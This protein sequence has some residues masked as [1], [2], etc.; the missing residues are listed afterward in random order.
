IKI[1]RTTKCDK[2]SNHL[3]VV[4][5]ESQDKA[6]LKFKYGS[7]EKNGYYYPDKHK[8]IIVGHKYY[9]P[10]FDED[11]KSKK[12]VELNKGK[13]TYITDNY[14]N[15]YTPY[16][17]ALF[18]FVHELGHAF[19]LCDQYCLDVATCS[20]FYVTSVVPKRSTMKGTSGLI[21]ISYDDAIGVLTLFDRFSGKERLF[22]GND[23]L[24]PNSIKL[25]GMPTYDSKDLYLKCK[26]GSYLPIVDPDY[27]SSVTFGTNQNYSDPQ[28]PKKGFW[29]GFGF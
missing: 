29:K 15:G 6:F 8:I 16:D 26:D 25:S 27:N 24:R 20:P 10:E 7:S 9:H 22:L 19:G 3:T 18:A 5:E 2:N 17:S 14:L 12:W 4:F 28:K 1:T 11:A 13:T 21:E 23:T